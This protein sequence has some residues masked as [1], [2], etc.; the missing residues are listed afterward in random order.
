MNLYLHRFNH[1]PEDINSPVTGTFGKLR[2]PDG[3]TL[4]T[5]ERPW[6]GNK[7]S[8]SCIP[9]GVYTLRKRRSGVVERSSKGKYLEGWEVCDVPGRTYI[10]NH[11]A[12]W[13][14]DVEGCIGYG[15]TY[16]LIDGRL[17]VGH[18]QDAFDLFMQALEG[19]EEHILHIMPYLVEYP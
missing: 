16:G 13:P 15:K 8:E 7:P 1:G 10:M 9:D 6:K 17:A 4:Y 18:S 2:L 3:K 19:E 11:P 5:V 14:T 12:N